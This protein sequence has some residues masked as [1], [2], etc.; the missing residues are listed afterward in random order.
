MYKLKAVLESEDV[1]TLRI[2]NEDGHSELFSN[3]YIWSFAKCVRDSAHYHHGYPGESQ[4]F[5]ECGTEGG[6]RKRIHPIIMSSFVITATRK[7]EDMKLGEWY[8]MIQEGLQ[9]CDWEIVE[10]KDV[11]EIAAIAALV[12]FATLGAEQMAYQSLNLNQ[13]HSYGTVVNALKSLQQRKIVRHERGVA[14]L[15]VSRQ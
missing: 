5:L 6:G 8:S 9:F 10:D 15:E 12:F 1:K 3:L 4:I 14:L 13:G 11:Q 2:T 7:T